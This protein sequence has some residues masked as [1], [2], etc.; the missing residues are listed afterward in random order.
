MTCWT[1]AAQLPGRSICARFPIV[2]RTALCYPAPQHTREQQR[3]ATRRKT[4]HNHPDYLSYL[5]RLWRVQ[6]EAAA[7]RGSLES[8]HTGERLGF[9]SL[10][11]LFA[12]LREQTDTC[13]QRA[14]HVL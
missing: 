8:P 2:F 11:E 6:G 10:D 1:L 3:W 9:G 4:R 5:L 14:I 13:R 12:F 7:W